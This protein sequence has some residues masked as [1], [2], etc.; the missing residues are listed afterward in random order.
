M[1]FSTTQ[2]VREV[3]SQ[4]WEAETHQTNGPAA[5]GT[6]VSLTL[7]LQAVTSP[8][9]SLRAPEE[10]PP[11]SPPP[12]GRHT[13]CTHFG[14]CHSGNMTSQSSS[15]LPFNHDLEHKNACCVLCPWQGMCAL[16]PTGTSAPRGHPTVSA[17]PHMARWHFHFHCRV[18]S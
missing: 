7:L 18:W 13:G 6:Q 5:S 15:V 11:A 9:G 2:F 3:L 12:A 8:A 14:M 10:G 16:S 1:L 4:P 17:C